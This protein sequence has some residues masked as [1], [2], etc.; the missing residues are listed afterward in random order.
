MRDL[1]W[2]EADSVPV[3][4]G[5]FQDVTESSTLAIQFDILLQP[6]TK[7]FVCL[8]LCSC[9]LQSDFTFPKRT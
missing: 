3:E 2:L 9:F 4:F 5:I 6:D 1:S 7:C 8:L